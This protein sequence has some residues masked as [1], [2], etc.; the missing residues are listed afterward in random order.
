MTEDD[1]RAWKKRIEELE[2]ENR[3]LRERSERIG[4]FAEHLSTQLCEERRRTRDRRMGARGGAERRS[5][6]AAIPGHAD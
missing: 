6:P 3:R 5:S 1:E 2:E 4:A